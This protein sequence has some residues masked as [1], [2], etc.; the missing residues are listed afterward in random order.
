MSTLREAFIETLKD[1]YDAENQIIKA[2]PKVIENIETDE[3]RDGLESHLEETKEHA[4]RLE[5]VF[6]I[7][8]ESPKAKK[9]KG[10]AGL[11]AEGEEVM[12][13]DEGEAALILA[14][15]KV[16]HYEIAAYGALVSWANLLEEEK[17]AEILEKTLTEEK[18]ADDKL[19]DVAQDI[20]NTEESGGEEEK[21]KAA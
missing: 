8:G 20:I 5:Q 12:A 19:T 6:E 14:L 2:L 21:R 16:E 4:K 1:T 17:A 10:M 13:E 7:L 9:C 18:N 11:I 15:Q 3:L